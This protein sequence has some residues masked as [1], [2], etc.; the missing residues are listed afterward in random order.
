MS[1]SARCLKYIVL[2][3][4]VLYGVTGAALLCAGSCLLW[5]LQALRGL[6]P[7]PALGP[8]ALL[9]VLGVAVI[10]AAVL[11]WQSAARLH[12]GRLVLFSALLV[13]LLLAEAG[14]AA[15]ALVLRAEMPEGVA[16]LVQESFSFAGADPARDSLQEQLQCCGANGP[17][18]YRAQGAVPWS[19]CSEDRSSPS[20]SSS[21]G[22]CHHVHQGGCLLK[23]GRYAQARLLEAALAAVAAFLLQAGG[24]FC[25]CCLCNTI[26]HEKRRDRARQISD[27]SYKL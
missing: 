8:P 12:R 13:L 21:S 7:R 4:A 26:E 23:V 16:R 2:S 17:A 5:L 11:G 1:F 19:C 24:V 22:D 27:Q 14:A 6:L 25:T 18:D 9:A 20:P 15:W 3:Y 10:L